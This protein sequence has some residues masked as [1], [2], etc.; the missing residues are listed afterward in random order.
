METMDQIHKDAKD[1]EEQI[2]KKNSN[3]LTQVTDMGLRS[4]ADLQTTKNKLTETSGEIET[5]NRLIQ[6][7]SA[8]IENQRKTIEELKKTW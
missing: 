2:K 3:S 4:K 1:E 8:Q 7:K 6:D 5:L